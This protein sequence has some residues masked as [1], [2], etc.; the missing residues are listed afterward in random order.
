MAS[1]HLNHAVTDTTTK[2]FSIIERLLSLTS[3]KLSNKKQINA[4][5]NDLNELDYRC[6]DITNNDVR[7][8][9]I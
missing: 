5:L 1:L 3:S 2:F 6:L 8:L 9:Y 4:H 7:N